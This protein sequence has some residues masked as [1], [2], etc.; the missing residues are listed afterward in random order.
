MK[1]LYQFA[2]ET[3]QT[4]K[5]KAFEAYLDE[6]LKWIQLHSLLAALNKA[7]TEDNGKVAGFL[8]KYAMHYGLPRSE[9]AQYVRTAVTSGSVSL[10]NGF[11][12]HIDLSGIKEEDGTLFH[13]AIK[14]HSKKS[15]ER[16]EATI[17]C[18][19]ERKVDPNL[20]SHNNT[21]TPMRFAHSLGLTE[22]V[23][24]LAPV[25]TCEDG[26]LLLNANL[27]PKYMRDLLWLE[28]RGPLS[29]GRL[30][31]P[32]VVKYCFQKAPEAEAHFSDYTSLS[33]SLQVVVRKAFAHISSYVNVDFVYD[34][35][36]CDL[37]LNSGNIQVGE[38]GGESESVRRIGCAVTSHFDNGISLPP[39]VVIINETLPEDQKFAVVEH[40]IMHTLGL[41]HI[42]SE[43]IPAGA[44]SLMLPSTRAV[45]N[46]SIP[47]T[48]GTPE[49]EALGAL[50]GRRNNTSFDLPIPFVESEFY[51]ESDRIMLFK[52]STL[53]S[54]P[55]QVRCLDAQKFVGSIKID[56]KNGVIEYADLMDLIYQLTVWPNRLR[57]QQKI[58]TDGNSALRCVKTGGLATAAVHTSAGRFVVY[59]GQ[60]SVI[61]WL[62]H[63]LPNFGK[64]L[65]S[66]EV[67]IDGNTQSLIWHNFST[68]RDRIIFPIT[69]NK[70]YVSGDN[71][72]TQLTLG[73]LKVTLPG[74]KSQELL[75]Q[76]EVNN[77]GITCPTNFWSPLVIAA[78]GLG[79]FE[80]MVGA[81]RYGI[82]DIINLLPIDIDERK[83][84]KEFVEMQLRLQ[85]PGEMM[86][87]DMTRNV[88]SAACNAPAIYKFHACIL[89]LTKFG[90]AYISGPVLQS[91]VNCFVQPVHAGAESWRESRSEGY[92]RLASSAFAF[93]NGAFGIVEGVA[94]MAPMSNLVLENNL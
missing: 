62:E 19:L 31:Q 51:C 54:L 29:I 72:G 3:C 71:K 30:G 56:I 48:I 93:F 14:T 40:E 60:L 65:P 21:V 37:Y 25:T 39:R 84:L 80:G 91:V 9:V 53:W 63:Y 52:Y 46:G 34:D 83:A 66:A 87:R 41:Q 8:C 89:S 68:K 5:V 57:H 22:V 61:A 67:T 36:Q 13:L 2:V 74:I 28:K 59:S 42:S 64:F 55:S 38:C 35:V 12:K 94:Q 82:L 33:Q 92:G 24:L 23:K 90:F 26:Q 88:V 86:A 47:C 18:L 32:A 76:C 78:V 27:M 50:Y 43:N 85:F 44:S 20:G 81:T 17:K 11:A 58:I 15:G 10:L 69:N 16:L 70:L 77:R 49:I 7:M 75:E 1:D 4:R 45:F 73:N 79:A 6:E